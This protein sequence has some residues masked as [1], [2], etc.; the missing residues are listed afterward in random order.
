MRDERVLGMHPGN[1]NVFFITFIY[2]LTFVR[3][4]ILIVTD[5]I[6]LID[7]FL[8]ESKYNRFELE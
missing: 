2:K 4:F 5:S 1:L 6:V 3:Y 8:L 7:D